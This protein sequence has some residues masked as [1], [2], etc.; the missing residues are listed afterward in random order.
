MTEE[1]KGQ[2]EQTVEETADTMTAALKRGAEAGAEAATNV[3]SLLGGW[4][5]N[6]AYGSC[7]YT[8]YGTTFAAMTVASL[9]PKGGILEKGFHDGAEAARVAFHELEA[10]ALPGALEEP[11][12]TAQAT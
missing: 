12:R 9:V 5:S 7:Y 1:M 2:A 8:A 10:P 3:L 11:T 6:A 4:M